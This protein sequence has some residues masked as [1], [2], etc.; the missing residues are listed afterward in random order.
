MGRTCCSLS[1]SNSGLLILDVG[2]NE[3]KDQG[4]EGKTSNKT[5]FFR[6]NEENLKEPGLGSREK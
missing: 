3:M 1:L 4:S 6:I 5:H 2:N